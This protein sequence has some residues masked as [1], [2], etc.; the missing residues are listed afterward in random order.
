MLTIFG[1]PSTGAYNTKT[2]T[3]LQQYV[4]ALELIRS[5]N[6]TYPVTEGTVCLGDYSDDLCWDKEGKGVKEVLSFNES[7]D[8]FVPLLSAGKIV[9]DENDSTNSREGYTYTSNN[10]GRGYVIQYALQGKNMRCGFGAELSLAVAEI[11]EGSITLC[12]ITR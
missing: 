12:A 3:Q 6:A 7:M 1:R 8:N 11:Q 4:T 2:V 10:K 5:E 9:V